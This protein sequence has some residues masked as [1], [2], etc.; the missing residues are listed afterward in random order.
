[1]GI[2][3]K[4]SESPEYDEDGNVST[5]TTTAVTIVDADIDKLSQVVQMFL[6]NGED[7]EVSIKHKEPKE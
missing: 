4:Y 5:T 2:K 7:V 6:D 3:I 1:M